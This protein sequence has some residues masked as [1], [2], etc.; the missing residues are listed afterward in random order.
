MR[1]CRRGER[2]DAEGARVGFVGDEGGV[3][4]LGRGRAMPTRKGLPWGFGVVGLQASD[5]LTTPTDICSFH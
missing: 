5:D 4:R 1:L 2:G 3:E